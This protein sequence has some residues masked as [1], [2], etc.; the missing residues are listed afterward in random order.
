[1]LIIIIIHNDFDCDLNNNRYI[2]LYIVRWYLQS[3]R[4]LFFQFSNRFD[5]SV[6]QIMV[7]GIAIHTHSRT[8]IHIIYK[9]NILLRR[10]GDRATRRALTRPVNQSPIERVR[11]C[12]H[13]GQFL[14]CRANIIFTLFHGTSDSFQK[15]L[16]THSPCPGNPTAGQC[17]NYIL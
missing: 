17:G 13:N 5:I 8:H 15:Q 14:R 6:N 11:C 1:M 16:G 2:C 7:I 3:D 4:M 10:Y 12:R 9:Y